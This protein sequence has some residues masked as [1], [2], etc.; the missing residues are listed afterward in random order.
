M[1]YALLSH[2]LMA[3]A[4]CP[5]SIWAQSEVKSRFSRS[6]TGRGCLG[7]DFWREAAAFCPGFAMGFVVA[8]GAI[9]AS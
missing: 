9:P 4:K 2:V 1:D 8:F 6:A 7:A 3:F 5:P